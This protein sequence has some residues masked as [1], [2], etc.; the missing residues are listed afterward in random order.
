MMKRFFL[1]MVMSVFLGASSA[2]AAGC[3]EVGKRVA[4]QESGVLVRL[5]PVVQDG[6]DMCMVVVVIPARE[7]EKLR[8]VEVFV[9]NN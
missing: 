7:G 9:P 6:Q 5:K 2:A 4:A 8:R 1:F 3:I